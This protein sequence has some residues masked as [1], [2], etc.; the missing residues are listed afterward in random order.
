MLDQLNICASAVAAG[1]YYLV[2]PASS[3]QGD[4]EI[5][6][7]SA[8]HTAGLSGLPLE[9]IGPRRVALL[10]HTNEPLIFYLGSERKSLLNHIRTSILKNWN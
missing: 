3:G 8:P 7:H 4:G 2:A 6:L 5:W 10:E 9:Y 1:L